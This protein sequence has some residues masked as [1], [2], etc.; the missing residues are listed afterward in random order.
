MTVHLWEQEHWYIRHPLSLL[1]MVLMFWLLLFIL[2]GNQISPSGDLF[3]LLA[4]VLC[5][6][7]AAPL[8]K[9]VH[10]PP[11]LGMLLAGILMRSVGFYHVSGIY[12]AIVANLR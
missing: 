7:I 12:P 8:A 5:A 10:L 1:T 6:A 4:L 9:L 2:L 11:L 3:R